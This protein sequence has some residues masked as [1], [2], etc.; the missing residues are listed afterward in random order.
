[1]S[2]ANLDERNASAAQF[3]GVVREDVMEKIWLIDRFPLPLTDLCAKDTSGNHYKEFTVDELGSQDLSNRQV[4]GA[5]RTG[6][7][8]V[9]GNRQGNYHNL[10]D[11]QIRVSHR[12][13]NVRSIG[14]QSSLS[15]QISRGQQRL[16][17]DVEGMAFANIA[18]NP[19]DPNTGSPVASV[20]S[21]IGAWIKTNFY[22]GTG[23]SAGGFNFT[24]G[25]IDA[26][27]PGTARALTETL[28]RDASQAC[29]QEGGDPSVFMSV[30][31]VKRKF[32]EYLF[33]SNA[34]IASMRQP[35]QKL[36][37]SDAV[38][39][40]DVFASDFS[41][42]QLRD[43]RLQPDDATNTSTVYILTPR[44]LRMSM[45]SGYRTL[46]LSRDGHAENRLISVDWTILVTNEKG[47]AQIK[48][49]NN[50]ADVTFS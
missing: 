41:I 1:M 10:S 6:N 7:N 43:N 30:P 39:T 37:G 50:N 19:G 31:A 49:V 24:T 15:Y 23:G 20:G 17:R 35:D 26:A 2:Q 14:R 5:S 22:G 32:S 16:R 36:S 45:L 38:G 11:K 42:L 33:T 48:A 4:D 44:L 3:G 18:N 34:R 29:Y 27:T 46:P 25:R 8:A 40:V 13:N 28:V 12:A 21:G 47:C 9:V